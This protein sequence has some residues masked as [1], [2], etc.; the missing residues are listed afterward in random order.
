MC[1]ARFETGTYH[2]EALPDF[3]SAGFRKTLRRL[4]DIFEGSEGPAHP[5]KW[6]MGVGWGGARSLQGARTRAIECF[7]AG[8][9]ELDGFDDERGT[10]AER[11]YPQPSEGGDAATRNRKNQ[12]G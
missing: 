10:T 2:F 9:P 6:A 8:V 1:R 4:L 12:S 3:S 5:G 11:A 7:A